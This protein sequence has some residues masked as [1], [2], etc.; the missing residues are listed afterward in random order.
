M[1]YLENEE[2]NSTTALVA[3][4]ELLELLRGIRANSWVTS[5][6]TRVS[7]ESRHSYNLRNF[8]DPE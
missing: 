2:C 5:A 4:D 6:T 8:A 7:S 3:L 1:I